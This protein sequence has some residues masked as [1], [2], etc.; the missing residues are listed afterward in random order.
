LGVCVRGHTDVEVLNEMQDLC[1]WIPFEHDRFELDIELGYLK[2]FVP[3]FHL[4]V[5]NVGVFLA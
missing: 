5:G 3:V 1:V 4:V 2:Q